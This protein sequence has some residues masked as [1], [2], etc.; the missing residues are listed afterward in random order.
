MSKHFALTATFALLL[1]VGA[2]SIAAT[3]TAGSQVA[4][5]RLNTYLAGDGTA[6]YALSL[7]PNVDVKPAANREIVILFDTSAS[8]TSVF[9]EKGLAALA[10]L[11]AGLDRGDRVRLFAVD[12]DAVPLTADFVAPRSA[13]M[14]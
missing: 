6:Y 5:P 10:A 7:S 11:N 3:T 9:R 4:E 14:D 8:Q 1:V 2:R 12:L 13:E